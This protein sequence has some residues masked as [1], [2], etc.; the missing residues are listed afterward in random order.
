MCGTRVIENNEWTENYTPYRVCRRCWKS[1]PRTE[2][3]FVRHN[4]VE[5]LFISWRRFVRGG[6]Y[7]FFKKGDPVQHLIH[8]M[9]FGHWP[10]VGPEIAYYM[11]VMAAIEWQDENYFEG[12]DMLVPVPLH[13][14]R[15]RER[16][17][18]QSYYIARGICEVTGIPVA[19]DLVER[20][21]ETH[22]QALQGADARGENVQGAFRLLDIPRVRNKHLLL[23]DDLITTGSTLN[24]LIDALYASR[25]CK[26]SVFALG[27][28]R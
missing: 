16:G 23:V 3:A 26:I 25:T 13:P 10:T 11:G 15:L 9:K 22:Q 14:K 20:V 2:H 4:D 28:A 17:Y 1:L 12:I 27:K 24:A 19:D 5:D 21:R 6:A 7:F 8:R 18:N